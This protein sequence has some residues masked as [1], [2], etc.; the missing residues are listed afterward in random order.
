[1]TNINI[2]N[3]RAWT[4]SGPGIKSW[5]EVLDDL[6]TIGATAGKIGLTLAAYAVIAQLILTAG[7]AVA[8]GLCWDTA[9]LGSRDL[10]LGIY[11][12]LLLGVLLWGSFWRKI[13]SLR[14]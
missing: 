3:S 4:T 6:K 5:G 13:G 14:N 12:F 7:I 9:A 10:W 2:R 8:R 1:M 11:L